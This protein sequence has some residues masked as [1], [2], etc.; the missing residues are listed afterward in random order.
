M[1]IIKECFD[2]H[3]VAFMESL[4]DAEFSFEQARQF[5]PQAASSI[6]DVTH[7]TGV[8]K[9]ITQLASDGPSKLLS[10]INTHAIADKSGIDAGQVRHGLEIIMLVLSKAIINKCDGILGAVSSLS[11]R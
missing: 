9:F 3:D 4:K 10:N 6:S 8:V 11:G 2:E 5:L 1:N 7:E